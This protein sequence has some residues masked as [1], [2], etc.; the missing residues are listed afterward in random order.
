MRYQKINI[1]IWN[2]EKFT[3]LDPDSQRVF[4]YLLTSPHSNIVGFYILKQGYAIEDLKMSSKDFGKSLAKICS[5][6]MAAYDDQL[7]V[8]L[9]KKY[10]SYNP[11]T[12]PNQLKAAQE[13]IHGLPKTY[14]FQEFINIIEGLPE[15]LTK[16]LIEGLSKDFGKATVTVTDKDTVT[17]SVSFKESNNKIPYEEIISDFNEK[18]G[19]KFIVTKDVRKLIKERFEDGFLFKHFQKVHAVMTEKWLHDPKMEQY[20]RP[21]TLYRAS[22]FQGYLNT[23]VSLSDQGKVSTMLDKN[24]RVFQNFINEGRQDNA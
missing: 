21:S 4:L 11:I 8:I 12:N 16:G 6:G 7:Q 17:D 20:L 24:K 14:L 10:L 2:D 23:T 1:R 5:Q 19:K 9:L 13:M 18:S 22:K 3:S 15:G